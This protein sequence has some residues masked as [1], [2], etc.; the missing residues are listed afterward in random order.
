MAGL[1]KVRAGLWRSLRRRRCSRAAST[2][3]AQR[4][5]SVGP[6]RRGVR[7]GIQ[8]Y[9]FSSYLSN[10]A[11]EITCPAPPAPPTPNCVAPPAPTTSAARLERVF[12]WLQ[13]QG[14]PQRRAL[15]LPG[16]SVP[17]HEP[18]DAGQHRRPAGAARAR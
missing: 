14:H 9:D 7:R 1:R 12:A 6:E 11:G 3:Q 15:R 2:A 13:S 4:A 5:P 18:G 8:L 17:G 16:Q 10:G